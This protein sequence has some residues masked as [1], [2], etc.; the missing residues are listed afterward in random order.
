MVD[1]TLMSY[2]LTVASKPKLTNSDEVKEAVRC[3]KFSKAPTLPVSEQGSKVSSQASGISPG[4]DI[5]CNS[6]H[7][8]PPYSVEARSSNLH[9]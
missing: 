8:S 9:P 6:T 7:S 3:L 5:Q 2:F 1:V 4:P